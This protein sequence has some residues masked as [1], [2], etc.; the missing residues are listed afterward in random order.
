LGTEPGFARNDFGIKCI[1]APSFAEIFENNSLKNGLLPITL[2]PTECAL[3]HADAIA[4]LPLE[5]DLEKLEIRRSNGEPPV[6]FRIDP[7]R[8]YC[9][10]EGL[11][12]IALTL[13]QTEHIDEFEKRRSEEWPWLNGLGHQKD[14]GLKAAPSRDAL[15]W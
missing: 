12:D 6:P 10:L 7:F 3:L 1:I 13:L 9:L 4:A 11:D 8:R 5:V 2:P 15:T 14:K